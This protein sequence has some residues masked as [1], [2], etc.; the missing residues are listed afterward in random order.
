MAREFSAAV[1]LTHSM[2]KILIKAPFHMRPKN[3]PILS[4]HTIGFIPSVTGGDNTLYLKRE[5]VLVLFV[6][7]Q[8]HSHRRGVD[9]RSELGS[10][11]L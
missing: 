4:P 1:K 3:D 6:V 7:K 10:S 9:E 2:F 5:W 11:H 8:H